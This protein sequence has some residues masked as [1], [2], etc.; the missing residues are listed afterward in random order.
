MAELIAGFI[1]L[2]LMIAF[3]GRLREL[4]LLW[5]YAIVLL[6]AVGCVLTPYVL[7]WGWY[8]FRPLTPPLL[9]PDLD[10]ARI[11]DDLQFGRITRREATKQLVQLRATRIGLSLVKGGRNE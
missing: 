4:D 7:R 1:W 3:V 2:G 6:S 5:A 8:K 9:H 10:E 11:K